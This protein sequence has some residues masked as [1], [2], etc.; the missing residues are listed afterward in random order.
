M[1][2][3]SGELLEKEFVTCEFGDNICFKAAKWYIEG[4]FYCT[5]HKEEV[6]KMMKEKENDIPSQSLL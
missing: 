3:L 5:E 2:F 1:D 6:V 4:F